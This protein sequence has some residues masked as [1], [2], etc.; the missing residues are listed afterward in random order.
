MVLVFHGEDLVKSREE[1]NRRIGFAKTKGAEVVRLEGKTANLED[2]KQA[3]EALSLWAD[4]RLVVVEGLF[5][6]PQ[7]K[8][9]KAILT[10]LR[11]LPSSTNLILWEGKKVHGGSLGGFQ[12]KEFKLPAII[13]RLLDSLTPNNQRQMLT[14]LEENKKTSPPEIIFYMLCR[15]VRLLI[16]AKDLGKGGLAPMPFWMQSKFLRQANHF[17]LE[18]L[19]KLHQKLLWIDYEQKTGRS[20]FS[21]EKELDL[22]VASL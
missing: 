8:R 13:F 4:Q 20:L 22:L 17:S 7:S 1:L 3:L 14:L 15:Q 21:L 12:A 10:Y 19:L 5:A 9:K 16:L 18:Q 11:Q 6:Q 2:F